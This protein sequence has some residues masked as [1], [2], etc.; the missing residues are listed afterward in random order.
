MLLPNCC[1]DAT[2]EPWSGARLTGTLVDQK[3]P[4]KPVRSEATYLAGQ[5]KGGNIWPTGHTEDAAG[6]RHLL[7]H[8]GAGGSSL[9]RT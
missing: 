4:G 7:E 2:S 9:S 8:H 1:P 5:A 6:G 3:G